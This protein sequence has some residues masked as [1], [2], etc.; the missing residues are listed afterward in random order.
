MLDL[1][2]KASENVQNS[3]CKVDDVFFVNKRKR[4][5]Q[6]KQCRWTLLSFSFLK[7]LITECKKE[8]LQEEKSFLLC[9]TI[10]RLKAK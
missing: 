6:M 5:F 7:V 10:V 3:V 2:V 9:E 4:K 8:K 1:N